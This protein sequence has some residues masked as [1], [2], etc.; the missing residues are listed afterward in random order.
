MAR[1]V[2]HALESGRHLVV[3]AGTGTGKTLAYL[4]PSF[5]SGRRIVV[6]TATKALQD[7]LADKDLPMLVRVLQPAL[8]REVS[9]A[10]L[11]GRSNY[12]CRQRVNEVG[13]R[14]TSSGGDSSETLFD[15]DDMSESARREV[16]RLIEWSDSTATGDRAE[17]TWSSSDAAWRAVSVG[18]DECPGA[19]KC[20]SGDSCFTELARLR[21]SEADI[22]VVNTHLYGAHVASGGVLLPDHDIVIV[23]EA[24]GLEDTMSDS[25]A[26]SLSAGRLGFLS[27]ALRRI[28]DDPPLT[29]R[30][31]HVADELTQRL[32]PSVGQRLS[33]PLPTPIT[34]TLQ[35]VRRIGMDILDVLRK[36]DAPD[37]S[38]QQR[39]LRAQSLATRIVE[40]IDKAVNITNTSVPFV[41]GFERNPHLDIAPL[42]VGPVLRESVWSTKTA[43]L[44]S[45]T[46]P[47]N[48]PS[49]I[50]LDADSTETLVVDSPF[51][52][53]SQAILYCTANFPAPNDP[54]FT[55]AMHEELRLLIEAAGGRT[56]ALFTSYRA[57]DAAVEAL[58]PKLDVTV[59]SQREYQKSQLVQMFSRDESSCLFATSGFFQGIDIPGR[60]LSLVTIDR[61]PFPRPDDPLL[62]ARREAVGQAAFRDI[63]IPRAA[64][65]LAQATGRLIRNAHDRGVV[66]VFDSRLARAGYRRDI[67]QAL[68]DMKRSIDRDEVVDFLR[69]VTS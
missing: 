67:L 50:G 25:V 60:T 26:I 51:D 61:I 8:D 69:N 53:R 36:I 12:I 9:W 33:V 62:S 5:L 68:P 22:I 45:A 44:T 10:V 66:A 48:L 43:V 37:E 52:Y 16:A 1:A 18:S 23:D 14:N 29:T 35:D 40:D 47:L 20:P 59:L 63:D 7:Q 34:D 24:H 19:T 11:K 65:L 28:V 42:D 30:I 4:V 13:A 15:V 49:R 64:T 41:S 56:L 31:S 17:L 57:L 55:E 46:V 2:A 39:K 27:S 21:A 38:T 3:Q 6:T 58:R 54:A 32:V